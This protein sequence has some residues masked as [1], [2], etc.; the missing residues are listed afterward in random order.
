MFFNLCSGGSL[1]LL[2]HEPQLLIRALI[3]CIMW[4]GGFFVRILWFPWLVFMALQGAM[5]QSLGTTEKHGL[6]TILI[7]C[8]NVLEAGLFVCYPP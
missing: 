4:T 8:G 3:I 5:A 7:I 1:D 6:G 2:S